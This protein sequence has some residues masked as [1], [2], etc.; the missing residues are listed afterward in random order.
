VCCFFLSP[1]DLIPLVIPIPQT[2]PDI[3]RAIRKDAMLENV[4][5]KEDGSP[6]YF[7]VSKTQ[8][9]RVSYP[10][11]HIPNYHQPQIAG[12]PKNVRTPPCPYS[13]N[14]M[15]FSPAHGSHH[16]GLRSSS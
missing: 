11:Y 6:D 9:G 12:H 15:N 5:L 3:Y 2:E 8:N 7:D 14:P 1:S 10:I 13:K 4:I 16:C